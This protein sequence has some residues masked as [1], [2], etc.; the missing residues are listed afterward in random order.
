MQMTMVEKRNFLERITAMVKD[1][2]LSKEDRD[3]IYR[4]CL[5]AC[6]RELARLRLEA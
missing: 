4:I 3:D 2:V 5:A 1:D 6:D